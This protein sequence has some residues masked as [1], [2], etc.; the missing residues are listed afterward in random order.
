VFLVHAA[1]EQKKLMMLSSNTSFNEL[2]AGVQTKFATTQPVRCI[3]MK[4]ADIESD[5]DVAA[6]QNSD[7]LVVCFA[8]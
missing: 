7:E 3:Q 5:T 8:E 2:L 4:G 1:T 6:L